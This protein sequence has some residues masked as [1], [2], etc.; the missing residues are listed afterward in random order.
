MRFE[1][2]NL[3]ESAQDLSLTAMVHLQCTEAGVLPSSVLPRSAT[4]AQ[5]MS[6]DRS[7]GSARQIWAGMQQHDRLTLSGFRVIRGNSVDRA[8]GHLGLP[9]QRLHGHLLGENMASRSAWVTL[10]LHIEQRRASGRTKSKAILPG[11]MSRAC[12]VLSQPAL[13]CPIR[14]VATPH[15]QDDARSACRAVRPT[16]TKS[17]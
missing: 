17:I 6:V 8:V 9:R 4:G 12:S 7:S 5:C 15:N 2:A 1:G 3:G 16:S 14:N 11:H 10:R 13:I